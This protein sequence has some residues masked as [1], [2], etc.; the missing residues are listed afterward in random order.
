MNT[1]WNVDSLALS[2][3]SLT[4]SKNMGRSR[5]VLDIEPL[6]LSHYCSST[7]QLEFLNGWYRSTLYDQAGYV[8]GYPEDMAL[9]L[10]QKYYQHYI[11][12]LDIPKAGVYNFTLD[13]TGLSNSLVFFDSNSVTPEISGRISVYLQTGIHAVYIRLYADGASSLNAFKMRLDSGPST[14]VRAYIPDHGRIPAIYFDS[15]HNDRLRDID[16]TSFYVDP[17]APVTQVNTLMASTAI[18]GMKVVLDAKDLLRYML[19]DINSGGYDSAG[20]GITPLYETAGSV[21]FSS[22]TVPDTIFEGEYEGSIVE[23]FLELTGIVVM[24]GNVPFYISTHADGTSSVW[25][26]GPVWV[27]DMELDEAW[28]H[29]D[30]TPIVYGPKEIPYTG[31]FTSPGELWAD[32][33]QYDFIL[34]PEQDIQ[35]ADPREISF[36]SQPQGDDIPSGLTVQELRSFGAPNKL[37]TT[38]YEILWAP[39]RTSVT[40]TL[41][42]NSWEGYTTMPII[43]TMDEIEVDGHY[44]WNASQRISTIEGIYDC[45]TLI[46]GSP[47]TLNLGN[48]QTGVPFEVTFD[49][50][51]YDIFFDTFLEFLQFNIDTSID[52]TLCPP[53]DS[54]ASHNPVFRIHSISIDKTFEVR[55]HKGID[56]YFAMT[57]PSVDTGMIEDMRFS[58]RLL[59]STEAIAQ[60]AIEMGYWSD[61]VETSVLNHLS[62]TIGSL[63]LTHTDETFDIYVDT[64]DSIP[65]VEVDFKEGLKVNPASYKLYFTPSGTVYYD[66][67]L[68]TLPFYWQVFKVDS[69][70]PDAVVVTANDEFAYEHW[71]P[72]TTVFLSRTSQGSVTTDTGKLLLGNFDNY[73][74]LWSVDTEYLKNNGRR[75]IEYGTWT[76]GAPTRYCSPITFQA[77]AHGGGLVVFGLSEMITREH[78]LLN[79]SLNNAYMEYISRASHMNVWGH[80]QASEVV[81]SVTLDYTVEDGVQ[82]FNSEG[83]AEELA[84]PSFFSP[85]VNFAGKLLIGSGERCANGELDTYVEQFQPDYDGADWFTTGS[86]QWPLGQYQSDINPGDEGWEP[87]SD[88]LDMLTETLQIR[89]SVI[90]TTDMD[91]DSPRFELWAPGLRGLTSPGTIVRHQILRTQNIRIGLD[92]SKVPELTEVHVFAFVEF[93]GLDTW[94]NKTIPTTQTQLDF[95][96]AKLF[97][98]DPLLWVSNTSSRRAPQITL[99]VY[100][101]DPDSIH[102]DIVAQVNNLVYADVFY[103]KVEYEDEYIDRWIS[104][105]LQKEA[106]SNAVRGGLVALGWG[107]IA[108]APLTKGVTGVWGLELLSQGYTGTGMFDHGIKG[109]MR[110]A[111]FLSEAVTEEAVYSQQYIEAFSIWHIVSDRTLDLIMQEVIAEIISFGIGSIVGGVAHAA[112]STS[113]LSRLSNW[114]ARSS[115]LGRLASPLSRIIGSRVTRAGVWLA[116]EYLEIVGEV[117]IEMVFDNMLNL[118]EG[119]RPMGGNTQFFA[120]MTLSVLTSGLLSAVSQGRGWSIGTRSFNDRTVAMLAI[121][122]LGVGLS[123]AQAVARMPVLEASARI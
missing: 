120:L 63:S 67:D 81:S 39:G 87:V 32:S 105:G 3:C 74:P 36:A 4:T 35:D 6:I 80:S 104:I 10:G 23:K 58:R 33:Y 70:Y 101:E 115:H 18:G 123:L 75:Y 61:G 20:H 56:P 1:V 71:M 49:L 110:F 86:S 50:S 25:A 96:L 43:V 107:L 77:D 40:L 103:L 30:N 19:R 116:Q 64:M 17:D 122:T 29:S 109:F 31:L 2:S 68:A 111:N 22:D 118:D 55:T 47:L 60:S 11:T 91:S 100:R 97:D 92:F 21:I 88:Q 66:S 16:S 62:S 8:S 99:F 57:L 52:W 90:E 69:D 45:G 48:I 72:E 14:D 117:I 78:T 51:K 24:D 7:A 102:D 76:E 44:V 37:G 114:V 94:M 59:P 93:A 82:L 113:R 83:W 106:D 98:F 26:R 108:I 9:Q 73:E 13:T 46:D 112:A 27:L 5:S 28:H 42:V 89:P 12:L 85:I 41:S 119:E 84:V 95:D 79:S 15:D 121:A 38:P 34:S 54:L 53:L 65:L